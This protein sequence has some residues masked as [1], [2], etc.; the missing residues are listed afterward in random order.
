MPQT[1]SK[2]MTAYICFD[3]TRRAARARDVVNTVDTTADLTYVTQPEFAASQKDAQLKGGPTAPITPSSF[4]D[5]QVMFHA[6]FDGPV[7]SCKPDGLEDRIRLR[8]K[9]YG[10]IVAFGELDAKDGMA[11]FRVEFH[12]IKAA[13]E[14]VKETTANPADIGV[15]LS[16]VSSSTVRPLY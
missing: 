14:V 5:G 16:K 9:K 4:Y 11:R 8:T 2:R 10:E 6:K 13:K 3:D 15:S 12:S 7:T 1:E